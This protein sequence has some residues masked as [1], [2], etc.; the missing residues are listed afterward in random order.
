M[1][2]WATE[3][4]KRACPASIWQPYDQGLASGD[5]LIPEIRDFPTFTQKVFGWEPADL[6]DFSADDEATKS[7][8]VA[9]AKENV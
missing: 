3:R 4:R 1:N 2:G 7:L 5:D 6:V 8:E 9:L